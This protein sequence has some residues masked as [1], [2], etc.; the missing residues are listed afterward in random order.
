MLSDS[1]QEIFIYPFH[2]KEKLKS[3]FWYPALSVSSLIWCSY[4]IFPTDNWMQAF[5]WNMFPKRLIQIKIN[6]SDL[7]AELIRCV[8]KICLLTALYTECKTYIGYH[9]CVVRYTQSWSQV[10]K[11]QSS[12]VTKVTWCPKLL[13]M[14]LL[15]KMEVVILATSVH[16]YLGLLDCND[17]KY[18]YLFLISWP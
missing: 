11:F 4:T 1:K 16:L 13:L 3:N 14:I 12:A 7:L 8:W 6:A 15:T 18:L 5:W 10:L 2:L 9:H 17:S